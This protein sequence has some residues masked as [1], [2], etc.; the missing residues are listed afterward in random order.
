V[1]SGGA[2]RTAYDRAEPVVLR[3]AVDLAG[4]PTTGDVAALIDGSLLRRPY[5]TVLQDGVKPPDSS[6]IATRRVA[7]ATV[8]GFM[9]TDGVRH[10]LASGATLKLNQVEDWHPLV[11]AINAELNS[12]FPAASKA[13]LFYTPAGKRGMLPHRDGS[14]VVAIQLEGE[15][16]WHLYG[17]PSQAAADPGLDID[18][19]R[20]EVVLMRPGDLLYLPHGYGH[21]AT[22]VDQTSLHVTFTLTEPFPAA[23]AS[24]LTAEWVAS[25]R[26]AAALAGREAEPS[27]A[28]AKALLDDLTQYASATDSRRVLERALRSA[29][30]RDASR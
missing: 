9:D 17:T 1:E 23:L 10:H 7:G 21:A 4:F 18:T 28:K 26:P 29:R 3:Q 5:F 15:K 12:C 16:E 24:A 14:R 30:T 22:A 6:V 8:K 27:A 20:D 13:F 25:G 11:G 2:L 19:S